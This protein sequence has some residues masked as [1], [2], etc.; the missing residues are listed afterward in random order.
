MRRITAVPL[1]LASALAACTDQPTAPRTSAR[2]IAPEGG[3]LAGLSTAGATPY[4]YRCY[5][6]L[7]SSQAAANEQLRAKYEAWR[8]T[9]VSYEGARARVMASADFTW[10]DE[11]G[12]T[13]PAPY[14]TISEGQGYAML[15]AAYM[16]DRKTFDALDQYRRDFRNNNGAMA[17]LV[18]QNGVVADSGAASDADE[19]IAMALLVAEKRWGGY[20]ANLANAIGVLKTHMVEP[21]TSPNAYLLRPADMPLSWWPVVFPGYVSPAWYRAFAAHTGD[22]FWT[23]VAEKSYQFLASIDANAAYQN[24]STGLL[25]DR[26]KPNGALDNDSTM[27]RFSWNAIRAPWRLAADAAWNCDTRAQGRL[28]KMNAFFSGT[29]PGQGPT[30]IGSVYRTNGDF[31]DDDLYGG[32]DRDPW[33]YGPLTSAAI[34][35]T[36]PTYK[37]GM[38]NETVG[39]TT[40]SR[41][42]HELGLLGLLMA[43]GNMHDP[44][45]SG[46][47]RTL[48]DFESGTTSG[49]WTY[50]DTNGSTLT[51]AVV[52]PAAAG[53]GMR[54]TY[55]I[56]SWAGVG[57]TVNQ[58]WSGYRSIEFWIEGAGTGNTIR[59]ELED[60]DGERFVHSFVDDFTGWRFASV[61][62][63]TTGFPRRTDWQP[64]TINNGMT[65]TNVKGLRF[66]P[67]GGQGTFGVDRVV[68][69]P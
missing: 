41:Y 29:G 49:W 68:L 39:M 51:K 42:G 6:S 46:G 4:A 23:Q 33:F 53:Y 56:A 32:P 16:G 48:N 35:S 66:E 40:F 27:H 3:P 26:A 67:L 38:W 14:A 34:A 31:L 61:P 25:P 15:L 45:A 17:W 1:L 12:V 8:S 2:G 36:N 10:T 60:A 55:G 21:A 57:T 13:R 54:I 9:R 5:G 20:T 28:A 22:A 30:G 37:Q 59:V 62:L 44:M 52:W 64:T 69:V 63:N 50:V 18:Y 19:D 65:L 47:R 43:S 7:V 24:G 11:H 58:D